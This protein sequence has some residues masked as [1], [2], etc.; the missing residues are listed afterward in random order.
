MEAGS[1]SRISL[2]L[3]PL[4]V[5][6]LLLAAGAVSAMD[7]A[8]E[9]TWIEP[10]AGSPAALLLDANDIVVP[11][12]GGQTVVSARV[13]DQ[14]GAPVAGVIVAFTGDLGSITPAHILSDASGAATATFTAGSVPGQAIVTATCGGLAQ[15]VTVQVEGGQVINRLDVTIG[16]NELNPGGQAGLIVTV[17]DQAAQPVRNELV[18]LFGTLGAVTPASGVSDANG[19]VLAVFNAGNAPGQ[20]NITALAGHVANSTSVQIAGSSCPD[21]RDPPGVGSEDVQD[22]ATRWHARDGDMNYDPI[23]DRSG[24]GIIDIEDIMAIAVLVDTACP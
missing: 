15:S 10:A 13:R 19:Q 5:L 8:A 11:L 4:L 14:A 22:V 17:Y 9:T 12:A 3:L 1:R 18:T 2:L 23:Y 7:E 21:F 6:P 24:D 20:A 16:V